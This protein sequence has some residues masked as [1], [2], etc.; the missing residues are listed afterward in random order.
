[1]SDRLEQL[2]NRWRWVTRPGRTPARDRVRRAI[3][4]SGWLRLKL[5]AGQRPPAG[6]AG[7]RHPTGGA[8]GAGRLLGR[9]P[10]PL[11]PLDLTDWAWHAR[12][13]KWGEH[14]Y[15]P[16]YERHLAPLRHT[17]FTL[18]EIGVGGYTWSDGGESLTMWQ[19][20]APRARIVA[21]DI[22]D[23]T[24]LSRGRIRVYHGSQVDEAVL[25]RIVAE[26]GPL[27]VVVDD[28]SHRPEHIR[29]TFRL[30]FPLLPDGAV[31]A[32]EDTQTSYWPTWGGSTDPHDPG[33]TMAM[34]KDLLDGLHHEELLGDARPPAA[35]DASVRAVHC[36]HNLVVIEKGD[37]REGSRHT[38]EPAG[39]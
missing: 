32:I 20:W 39:T 36:Y 12:T 4:E 1:M 2:R 9:L 31:Y 24:H 6:P 34:V 29:E 21:L 33:T 14:W 35:T 7:L 11:R 8:S 17:A 30:L 22:E 38:P 26:Q 23:K 15:T 3:G 37:N 18:L 13:D 5:A 10:A 28:G 19:G 27:H 16:H 25:R